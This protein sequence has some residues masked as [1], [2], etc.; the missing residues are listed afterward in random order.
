[1]SVTNVSF[2]VVIETRWTCYKNL[3]DGMRAN[4][5]SEECVQITPE[6][7]GDIETCYERPEL[8]IRCLSLDKRTRLIVHTHKKWH[9]SLQGSTSYRVSNLRTTKYTWRSSV[10]NGFNN[11]ENRVSSLRFEWNR[12]WREWTVSMQVKRVGKRFLTPAYIF[13]A[14]ETEFCGTGSRLPLKG[15]PHWSGSSKLFPVGTPRIVEVLLIIFGKL[16]CLLSEKCQVA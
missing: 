12:L 14:P 4:K 8:W 16:D 5:I 2:A 6:K 13:F 15:I 1:M 10:R 7:H 9:H 3:D 11:L